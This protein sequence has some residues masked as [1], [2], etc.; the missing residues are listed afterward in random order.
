M[1]KPPFFKLEERD[2]RVT[3]SI[4]VWDRKDEQ[5]ALHA[6]YPTVNRVHALWIMVRIFPVK[7]SARFRNDACQ[8]LSEVL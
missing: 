6:V 5:G 7:I 8:Q 1:G 2:G 4:V 3:G